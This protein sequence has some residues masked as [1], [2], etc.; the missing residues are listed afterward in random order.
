MKPKSII[1]IIIGILFTAGILTLSFTEVF[2]ENWVIGLG[3]IGISISFIVI[4]LITKM[5]K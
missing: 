1:Y 5:K 3:L 4:S 2:S